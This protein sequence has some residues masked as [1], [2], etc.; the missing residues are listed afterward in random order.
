[1]RGGLTKREKS[2]TSSPKR[3]PIIEELDEWKYLY[4]VYE[5]MEFVDKPELQHRHFVKFQMLKEKIAV[6]FAYDVADY[7]ELYEL[8]IPIAKLLKYVPSTR[9]QFLEMPNSI[10]RR[11]SKQRDMLENAYYDSFE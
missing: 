9:T 11:F 1:M 3:S 4:E 10:Y 6:L 2:H 5:D 7:P 8:I